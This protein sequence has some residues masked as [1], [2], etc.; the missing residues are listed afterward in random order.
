MDVYTCVRL[1]THLYTCTCL[2]YIYAC[3]KPT[4]YIYLYMHVDVHISINAYVC[5]HTS[6][7]KHTHIHMHMHTHTQVNTPFQYTPPTDSNAGQFVIDLPV[8]ADSDSDSA[9]EV[10]YT[11]SAKEVKKAKTKVVEIAQTEGE[12]LQAA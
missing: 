3:R 4:M 8:L 6:T 5:I 11:Y 1:N 10:V 2:I 12:E 9:H 7:H